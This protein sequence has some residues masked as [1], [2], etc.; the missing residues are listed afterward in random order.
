MH[1]PELY[2][3]AR[4]YDIHGNVIKWMRGSDLDLLEKAVR[5]DCWANADADHFVIDSSYD[6]EVMY[7]V[8]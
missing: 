2:F 5:R 7:D 6:E 1:L 8:I 4:I 3:V